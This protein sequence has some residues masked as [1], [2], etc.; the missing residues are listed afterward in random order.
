MSQRAICS[1]SYL[2]DT[3]DVEPCRNEA[4]AYVYG[5]G[6]PPRAYCDVCLEEVRRRVRFISTRERYMSAMR[7]TRKGVDQ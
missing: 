1:G 2:N 5:G 3:G 7:R 6:R 4:I